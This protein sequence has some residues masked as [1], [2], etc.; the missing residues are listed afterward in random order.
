MGQPYTYRTRGSGG[1][2]RPGSSDFSEAV[3][4]I[5]A[6]PLNILESLTAEDFQVVV[7]LTP[8]AGV[9]QRAPGSAF[10]G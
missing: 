3:D 10:S 9:Y 1:L 5:V 2:V 7:D 6:G 4:I 8:T